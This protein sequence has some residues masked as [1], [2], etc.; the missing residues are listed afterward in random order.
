MK[1]TLLW[2]LSL[3]HAGRAGRGGGDLGVDPGDAD[4]GREH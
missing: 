2:I 3:F 4:G 1:T